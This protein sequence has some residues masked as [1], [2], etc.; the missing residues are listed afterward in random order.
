MKVSSLTEAMK[1]LNRVREKQDA[2]EN[3][4]QNSKH[5]PYQD[6]KKKGS[7]EAPSEEVSAEKV[8]EAIHAFAKDAQ[9]QAS[10]LHAEALGSGPGLR[11]ILK[12]GSGTV[13]RSLTGEE[14]LKLREN[15][16][17]D[18]HTRGKI[19]DQKL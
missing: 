3:S 5:N 19:L 4:R 1:F 6:Q 15:A 14:F 17:Q 9:T 13:V 16:S 7:K 11:V 12:D 10:G 8:G 2:G 18:F